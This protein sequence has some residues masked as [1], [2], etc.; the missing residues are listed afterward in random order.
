[1]KIPP[2]A[3]LLLVGSGLYWVLSGP[4]IGWFSVLN[5]TQIHLS[6]MGVTLL[7]AIGITTLVVG[8]WIVQID[9]QELCKLFSRYDGWIFT[10][11]IYLVVADICLTLIGLSQG[12]WELNPFVASAVQIGPWAVVPFLVSYM[13]LSEGLA[14]MMLSVGKWLFGVERALGYMPFALV[15]GVAS[16]GSF[17]N[18]GLVAFPQA[19]PAYYFILITI[20]MVALSAGIYR[21]FSKTRDGIRL[22]LSLRSAS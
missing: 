10:I 20:G 9:F 1:L 19:G 21:H 16:F 3:G 14:L 2:G 15:C 6:Q 13:A 11:P 22:R 7:L 5:P 18:V 4:L 12:N 17:S 8:F